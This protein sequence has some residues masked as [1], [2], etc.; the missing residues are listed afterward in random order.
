MKI[1]IAKMI[2]ISTTIMRMKKDITITKSKESNQQTVLYF[3]SKDSHS[4]NKNMP[5]SR[6][7][8]NLR[9]RKRWERVLL[10]LEETH[11]HRKRGLKNKSYN[12]LLASMKKLLSMIIKS[13]NSSDSYLQ[14]PHRYCCSRISSQFHITY[15]IQ[16]NYPCNAK[17]NKV[18]L[19]RLHILKTNRAHTFGEFSKIKVHWCQ[20]VVQCSCKEDKSNNCSKDTI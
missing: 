10:L 18:L 15:R 4:W 17:S 8:L 7:N 9:L 12:T 11:M 6:N 5:G 20:T 16:P 14:T 19:L 2:T 13:S 3:Y 1:E